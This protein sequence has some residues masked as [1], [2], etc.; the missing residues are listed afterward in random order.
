MPA[1]RITDHAITLSSP[2]IYPLAYPQDAQR[3]QEFIHQSLAR[4]AKIF[5][6]SPDVLKEQYED[7]LPFVREAFKRNGGA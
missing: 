2:C 6:L 5:K 3:R 7:F 1:P 4:L